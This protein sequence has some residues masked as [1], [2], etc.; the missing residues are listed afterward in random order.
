MLDMLTMM[1]K[2][3]EGIMKEKIKRPTKVVESICII[4]G[5]KVVGAQKRKTC[6]NPDCKKTHAKN[7]FKKHTVKNKGT[8]IFCQSCGRSVRRDDAVKKAHRYLVCK[9]CYKKQTSS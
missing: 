1:K 5:D 3:K 8:L 2:T 9:N 4:C 7:R 6:D